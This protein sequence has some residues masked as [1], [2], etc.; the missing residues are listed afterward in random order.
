MY[1][2][3]IIIIIIIIELKVKVTQNRPQRPRGGVEV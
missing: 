1:G 2:I 3:I